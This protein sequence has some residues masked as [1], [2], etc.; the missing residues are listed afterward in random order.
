[1]G[2]LYTVITISISPGEGGVAAQPWPNNFGVWTSPAALN[3]F[4]LSF[5]MKAEKEAAKGPGMI[6][7][8]MYT[9]SNLIGRTKRYQTGT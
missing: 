7:Q 9:K 3:I 6:C 2:L 4:Q 1:M 5:E 8:N